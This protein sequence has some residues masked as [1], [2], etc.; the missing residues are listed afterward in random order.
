MSNPAQRLYD[1]LTRSKRKELASNKAL[2]AW[3]NVLTLPTDMDDLIV[4]S[5]IGKVLT[6]PSII[7]KQVERF[8]DLTPDL[9][10]GWRNDLSA[11]FRAIQF[12]TTFG[13]FSNRLSESMLINIRFCADQ[14][15]KRVPEKDVSRQE[16]DA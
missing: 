2:V 15:D 4:M 14:L 16:L 9:Y 5:K 7:T 11:A 6:L 13:Q 12:N 3:R 8:P 1:I 10:L